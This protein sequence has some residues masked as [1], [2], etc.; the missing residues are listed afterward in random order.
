MWLGSLADRTKRNA[1]VCSQPMAAHTQEGAK[2][3]HSMGLGVRQQERGRGA[4]PQ[5]PQ[6]TGSKRGWTRF[7][8]RKENKTKVQFGKSRLEQPEKH[9]LKYTWLI[10]EGGEG[11][12]SQPTLMAKWRHKWQYVG[13]QIQDCRKKKSW[14]RGGGLR[15]LNAPRIQFC[16]VHRWLKPSSFGQC[17]CMCKLNNCCLLTSTSCSTIL[18]EIGNT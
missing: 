12:R 9:H 18:Q 11:R 4:A 16:K 1:G 6:K 2:G 17:I 7:K 15:G 5:K 14:R 8:W 13:N 3:G 10:V